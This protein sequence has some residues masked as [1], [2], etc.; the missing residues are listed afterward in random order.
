MI[1]A[2]IYPHQLFPDHPACRGVDVVY[3]IEDPLFFQQYHFHRLKLMLHRASMKRFAASHEKAGRRVHYIE[4]ADLPET[5]SVV[6]I[7]QRDRIKSVQYVDPCDDR[8]GTRLAASLAQAKIPA[9]I[10]DDPGF[11][12]PMTIIDTYQGNQRLLFTKFY[13]AQR[14]RLKLLLEAGKP[15]GGKWSFDPENRKR[16]PKNVIPPPIHRP[17]EH[18]AVIEARAYVR[19]AFPHALGDDSEFHYPTNTTEARAVLDDFV[20]NRLSLFGDYEDSISRTHEVLYHSIL[21]PPLNAGLISPATVVQA[22]IGAADRVP[23][24]SLEG[25]IRQMIGWREFVRLVYL[26]RGRQQRTHNFWGFT[27]PMPAGFYDGTTGIDPVDIVIR[28]VLRTGYCH[29]I[30]RL[31]ILGG[32]MMLC[33]IHPDAVYQWFMELYTDAYDWVMVPNVYG[34]SQYADGGGMTTKPY[35]SGSAYVLKMS[36]FPR[37]KWCPVWDALYW[38][39]ID[40]HADFFSKNPRMA[41]M[42]KMKD[43][44]G[45]KMIEHHRVAEAFLTK[46]HGG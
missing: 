9:T 8:L 33:E 43:K 5:A 45:S 41:V 25:F 7:L 35:I 24:N 12:T 13:I 37:G 10:L 22:A 17:A 1:A 30:E 14:T 16:L 6:A 28:R 27:N 34:M 36:D 4:S 31:M 18:G 32:F 2:L 42:V 46:L 19:Q 20:Q 29:H 44:L 15:I 21:G 38:R 3:L 11:L 39:F 23:I 40:R 26:T